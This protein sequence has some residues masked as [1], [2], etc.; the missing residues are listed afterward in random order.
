MQFF[1]GYPEMRSDRLGVIVLE[2]RK[3]PTC[4]APS[5][6]RHGP[7]AKIRSLMIGDNRCSFRG[8]SKNT[9]GSSRVV[10]W[11]SENFRLFMHQVVCAMVRVQIS[12]F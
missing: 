3:F 1:A 10:F 2:I 8:V 6:V 7:G 12:D 11:K 9:I 5:G 4:H